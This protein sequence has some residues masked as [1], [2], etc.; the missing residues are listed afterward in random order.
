LP[1]RV[2]IGSKDPEHAGFCFS[3]PGPKDSEKFLRALKKPKT[4]WQWIHE[5]LS[6]T[7]NQV[8]KKN[9]SADAEDDTAG[10]EKP[11]T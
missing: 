9:R 7:M 10:D 11:K 4:L 5:G 3:R 8:N 6:A 1:L 2:G